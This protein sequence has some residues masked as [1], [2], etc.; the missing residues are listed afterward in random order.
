LQDTHAVFT[1]GFIFDELPLELVELAVCLA[2][3]AGAA[4]C[5]DPG[6]LWLFVPTALSCMD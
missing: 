3:E 6:A 4:V 1:N 5:F 2:S